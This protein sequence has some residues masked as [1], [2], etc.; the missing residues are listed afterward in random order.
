MVDRYRDLS[1]KNLIEKAT[2]DKSLA[3]YD[4]LNA[5]LDEVNENLKNCSITSAP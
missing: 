2:Y 1:K 4:K 3:D 5:Q